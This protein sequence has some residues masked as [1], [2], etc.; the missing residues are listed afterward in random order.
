[1]VSLIDIGEVLQL[2]VTQMTQSLAKP[3]VPTLD[4]KVTET[5]LRQDHRLLLSED[6]EAP[7]SRPE[8]GL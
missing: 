6:S 4:G 5:L 7:S 8:A 2:T 1:M 3:G